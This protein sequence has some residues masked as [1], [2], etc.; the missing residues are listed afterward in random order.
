MPTAYKV[1]FGRLLRGKP[2]SG[3]TRDGSEATG[4]GIADAT[5][6]PRQLTWDICSNRSYA[7]CCSG[8]ACESAMASKAAWWP[9]KRSRPSMTAMPTR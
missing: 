6:R 8:G 2:P 3:R 9:S 4:R 5:R 1:Y 7:A